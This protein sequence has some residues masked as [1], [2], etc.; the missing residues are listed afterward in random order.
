MQPLFY[1]TILR[2]LMTSYERV[3]NERKMFGQRVFPRHGEWK[4]TVFWS[5]FFGLLYS[6]LL[7]FTGAT[8]TYEWMV[9]VSIVVVLLALFNQVAL[10]S[11][12]Y[13]VSVT[14]IILFIL[15]EVGVTYP[16]VEEALL[17]DFTLVTYLL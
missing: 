17:T 11:P 3:K 5:M 15:K 1:I 10:L 2:A 4:K 8:M 9:A 16:F 7:I 14:A 6:A 12:G 13:T